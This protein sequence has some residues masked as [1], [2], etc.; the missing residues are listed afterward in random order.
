MMTVCLQQMREM[1]TCA[2]LVPNRIGGGLGGGVVC[3]AASFGYAR[4]A[5][6]FQQRN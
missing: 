5:T 1:A 4:K 3:D 2:C 6:L